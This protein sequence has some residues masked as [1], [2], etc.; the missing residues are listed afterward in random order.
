MDPEVVAYTCNS[1]TVVA[2]AGLLL[3]QGQRGYIVV[4][5]LKSL[6]QSIRMKH[7]KARHEINNNMLDFVLQS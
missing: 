7:K 1:G 6:T 5:H 3:A 4:M 2:K